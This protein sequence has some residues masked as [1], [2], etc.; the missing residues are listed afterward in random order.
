V[1]CIELA[2]FLHAFFTS[3]NF[4]IW[5]RRVTG[6]DHFPGASLP[7]VVK[8]A[9][10]VAVHFISAPFGF[11]ND[12]FL[13]FAMLII[14]EESPK[15]VPR[16]CGLSTVVW[17]VFHDDI[18]DEDQFLGLPGIGVRD[19]SRDNLSRDECAWVFK[20]ELATF[21]ATWTLEY[22]Y[23]FNAVLELVD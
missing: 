21:S 18:D 10:A 17:P 3:G 20:S 23:N 4:S 11:A 12:G 15:I 5:H 22:S 1:L 6:I 19:I 7:V 16:A 9:T 8:P 14:P 2:M 13:Y